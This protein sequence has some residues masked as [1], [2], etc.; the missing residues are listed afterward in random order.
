MW[1]FLVTA[2]GFVVLL[3]VAAVALL[4]ILLLVGWL[5]VG[6]VRG[7]VYALHNMGM[8]IWRK[9]RAAQRRTRDRR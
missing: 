1:T 6:L 8:W 7:M 4:A 2:V 9:V 3:F 5:V